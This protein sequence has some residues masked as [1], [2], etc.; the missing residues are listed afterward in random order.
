[1]LKKGLFLSTKLYF[2]SIRLYFSKQ[3][4][5]FLQHEN[6]LWQMQGYTYGATNNEFKIAAEANKVVIKLIQFLLLVFQE[7]KKEHC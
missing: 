3:K 2:L 1:M 4:N 6:D 5:K 7:I